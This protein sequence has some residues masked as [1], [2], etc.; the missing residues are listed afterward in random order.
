MFYYV[1]VYMCVHVVV[2]MLQHQARTRAHLGADVARFGKSFV[3][4][5]RSSRT[6]R[7]RATTQDCFPTPRALETKVVHNLRKLGHD[8][9]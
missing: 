8:F 5:T 1:Y 7:A 3:E 4:T 9:G 2:V 6:K